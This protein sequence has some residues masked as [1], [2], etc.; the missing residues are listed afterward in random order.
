MVAVVLAFAA[1]FLFALGTVC[2]QKGTL[3]E[4]S[5]SSL[6]ADFLARLAR[7]PVWLVGVAVVIVG[8]GL[9]AWALS[10]GRLIVVQPIQVT[11]LVFALPLGMWLTAQVVSRREVAGAVM[12]TGGLIAFVALANTTGGNDDA[13]IGAWAIAGAICAGVSAVLVIGTL[14]SRPSVRATAV[15]SAS[16]I[17]FGLSAALT[18]SA[19]DDW[20]KRV[21]AIITDWHLYALIVVAIAAFWL[22]QIALQN[23]LELAIATNQALTSAVAVGLAILLFDEAVRGSALEAVGAAAALA[24]A[25]FGLYVLL[26]SERPPPACPSSSCSSTS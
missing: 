14:R 12:V 26:L 19:V 11:S 17:L 10:L 4:S 23:G 20:G 25:V 24:V 5:D 22:T 9:Q 16:G 2:Q 13:S 15:G 6:R 21:A 1:A 7:Q 18:V 3:E 8:F